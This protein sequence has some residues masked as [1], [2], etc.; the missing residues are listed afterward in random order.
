MKVLSIKQSYFKTSNRKSIAFKKSS[1]NL[2]FGI[3][4]KHVDEIDTLKPSNKLFIT[5]H[6]DDETCFFGFIAKF[7]K[8]PNEKI[9][10]IYTTSG[11]KGQDVRKIIPRYDKKMKNQ[12]E[13]EL[14]EALD[15]LNLKQEPLML[16][17][18]DGE[19]HFKPNRE[20]CKTLLKKVIVAVKPKE[21]YTF[22]YSGIT[23]HTDHI[24]VSRIIEDLVKEN[25]EQK[26]DLYEV[27][28]SQDTT[29]KIIEY[30]KNSTQI[31]L[32]SRPSIYKSPYKEID[33]TNEIPQI[34]NS[35]KKYVSQFSPNA[36]VN[37]KE[38][39]KNNPIITLMKK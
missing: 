31:F 13:Q 10:L 11:Q 32:Y 26:I 16:D 12:R 29:D 27:G 14:S 1:M 17:L 19:T 7:L 30:T 28:F 2:S 18:M 15:E 5:A 3:R 22:D 34:I 35:L 38:Y 39:F 36:C 37:L 23:G 6:P 33:I 25:P 21:I 24:Q 4:L 8:N 20:R 9:Q